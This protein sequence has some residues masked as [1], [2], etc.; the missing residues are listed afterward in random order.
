M[1]RILEFPVGHKALSEPDPQSKSDGE[2]TLS[3][4]GATFKCCEHTVK[5]RKQ[6]STPRLPRV[7]PVLISHY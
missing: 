1:G 7:S 5:D 2:G 4:K 6:C 3:P